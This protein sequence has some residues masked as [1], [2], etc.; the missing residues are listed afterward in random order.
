MYAN[1]EAI[2]KNS[3]TVPNAMASPKTLPTSTARGGIVES[4]RRDEKD[5]EC[6]NDE[7]D[8]K[9]CHS[10]DAKDERDH[11]R[12][13]E[14]DLLDVSTYWRIR[15]AK[16]YRLVKEKMAYKVSRRSAHDGERG[17]SLGEPDHSSPSQTNM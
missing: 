4:S 17:D 2:R 16:S 9:D 14:R 12:R 6:G 5:R 8:I 3:Q 11:R 13:D 7:S 10:D 15:L 1:L